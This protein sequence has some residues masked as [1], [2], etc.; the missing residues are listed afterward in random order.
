[1]W[2]ECDA[3]QQVSTALFSN[4]VLVTEGDV[5][6]AGRAAVKQSTQSAV[7]SSDSAHIAD[8]LKASALLPFC[9]LW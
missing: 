3:G 5:Q 7:S 8:A 6:H 2:R 9:I 4:E 1:M